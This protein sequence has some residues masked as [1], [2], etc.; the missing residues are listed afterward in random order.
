MRTGRILLVPLLTAALSGACGSNKPT[1]TSTSTVSGAGGT[2]T[3]ASSGTGGAG[4]AACLKCSAFTAPNIPAGMV[5]AGKSS[6]LLGALVQC[7]C[8]NEAGV[9]SCWCNQ[10][11]PSPCTNCLAAG[12]FPDPCAM[13]R[14]A[15]EADK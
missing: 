14:A 10:P 1:S 13:Q 7:E 4:G 15:C 11:P 6:Q 3:S 5:C 12:S 2:S 9:C 8:Q